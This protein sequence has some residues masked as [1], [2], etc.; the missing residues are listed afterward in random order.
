MPAGGLQKVRDNHLGRFAR[1]GA[2]NADSAP[3]S[4]ASTPVSVLPRNKM[5]YLAGQIFAL[6]QHGAFLIGFQDDKLNACFDLRLK[7]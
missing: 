6:K 3:H 5:T 1:S 2:G 4:A 7:S